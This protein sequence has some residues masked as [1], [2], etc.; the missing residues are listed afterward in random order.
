[1][2]KTDE[3][4]AFII[5][6]VDH[7]PEDIV[8]LVAQTFSM[9]RQ[10]AHRHI[11]KMIA[12]NSLKA[13]GA[14]K[15]RKYILVPL[16]DQ[17]WKFAV[18]DLEEDRVWRNTVAPVLQGL[19]ENV[20]R[21]CQHGVTE[22]VNNAIDHSD[23][24]FISVQIVR[25]PTL[26]KIIVKD[27]GIGIFYKITRDFKLDDPLHAIL[28]LSKG[29]LT[30]DPAKHSGEGIFFTSR[31]FDEFSIMSGNLFFSHQSHDEDT[32]MQDWLLEVKGK[33]IKGTV[34]QM[35]I[36]ANSKRTTLQV[37]DRYTVDDD[38]GFSKTYVPVSLAQYGDDNLISRSQAR[39]LLTRFERFKEIILD[40]RNVDSIG[41]AFADEVFRVFK[42]AHPD[43]HLIPVNANKDVMKMI[44]RVSSENSL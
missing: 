7:H 20:Y 32:N 27:D 44:M 24:K 2:K 4:Y 8:S 18:A 9:S 40:F 37:F 14:T 26:V 38:F 29:K 36:L 12:N 16:V 35:E 6:N 42:N 3:I 39:R 10:A 43:V 25:T 17:T 33:D 23:G 22:M 13:E 41:Q 5:E 28:E 31:M 15:S 19:A 21:I 30:T 11:T 34:V 1:M